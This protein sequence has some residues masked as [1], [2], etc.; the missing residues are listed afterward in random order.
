MYDSVS[1]VSNQNLIFSEV[2]EEIQRSWGCKDN[3]GGEFTDQN[4]KRGS[5]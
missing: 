1:N 3:E 4:N 5:P 2:L